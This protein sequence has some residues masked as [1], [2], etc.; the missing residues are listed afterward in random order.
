MSAEERRLILITNDDG[1][2]SE[3]LWAAVEA[4][5][6]M[7][8]VLVV[9]PDRQWSGA[10]RSVPY[11]VTLW[12]A[13]KSKLQRSW[14]RQDGTRPRLLELDRAKTEFRARNAKPPSNPLG[15]A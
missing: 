1:I 6:P 5:L 4:V 15:A 13:A 3:A 9:A 11:D 14:L 2:D 7:G 12:Y 10:G 8:E